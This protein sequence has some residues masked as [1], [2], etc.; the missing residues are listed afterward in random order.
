MKYKDSNLALNLLSKVRHINIKRPIFLILCLLIYYSSIAQEKKIFFDFTSG[1]GRLY[2]HPY[3]SH[4][5]GPVTFFNARLGLKT[6]GQKEWQRIYNYPLLGI[7][8]SHNYLTTRSLGNPTAVYSFFILPLLGKSELKLNLGLNLGVAWGFNPY[9][10]QYPYDTVIGSPV[11]FYTSVNLNTSY[12]ITKSIELLFAYQFCHTSNGNTN[13][14]NYGI[15]LLGAEAGLR[16][17]FKNPNTVLIRDPVTPVEKDSSFIVFGSLGRIQEW[18]GAPKSTVGSISAGYYRTMNHKS[19][20]STGVDLFYDE[21]TLLETHKKNVLSNLL[22]GGIFVGHELTISKFSI[23]TQL[24][25]YV[26]NPNPS[27]PFYYTRIGLRYAL[28]KRIITSFTMKAHGLAVD[29][30]EWGF[31][32]VLWKSGPGKSR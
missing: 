17:T 32:Y 26:L 24:G 3:V 11:A 18:V 27:D 16:Y 6:L 29:F 8:I 21:A 5:A 4:L 1:G 28:S 19:R 15:N 31:G 2:P 30:L 13:K 20:L 23:V 9:R 25:V 14:P 12:H 10:A 7:G 22:A